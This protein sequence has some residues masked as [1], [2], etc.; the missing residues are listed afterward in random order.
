MA[1][2]KTAQVNLRLHPALKL[3]AEEAAARDHRSLNSLVEKLLSD[4]LRTLPT[5]EDWHEAAHLRFEG[6]LDVAKLSPKIKQGYRVLSYSI[7]TASNEK[8]QS[9]QLTRCMADV[10]HGLPR[11][12]SSPH[13]LY[14]YTRPELAPYFTA[15]RALR[16]YESD[17]ILECTVSPD[18]AILEDSI[19]LWRASPSGLVTD[20]HPYRED[21]FSAK[22]EPKTLPPRWFSPHWMIRD[23]G[24]LIYHSLL[25]SRH[26]EAV[27]AITFRCEWFGL[28]ER[29][30]SELDPRR[31]LPGNIARV[32]RRLTAGEWSPAELGKAWPAAAS[33]LVGPVLRLFDPTLECAPDWIS[34]VWGSSPV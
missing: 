22:N 26:F 20:I 21:Q 9:S 6:L 10:H 5:L 17:E 33:V 16:R 2:N 12:V 24:E 4:F 7:R 19:E 14:P 25:M 13:L 28:L 34:S 1:D 3:A 30:L 18:R 23:V 29:E 32:D 8:L 11:Y 31:F 15:D 27:E